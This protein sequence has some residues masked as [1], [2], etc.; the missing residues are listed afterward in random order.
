MSVTRTSAAVPSFV[1]DYLTRKNLPK[2]LGAVK[3]YVDS[4]GTWR[5]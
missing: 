1:E 2:A 5:R 3:K 4:G